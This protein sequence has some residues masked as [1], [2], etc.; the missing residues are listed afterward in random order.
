LLKS[1]LTGNG[2]FHVE[3][4]EESQANWGLSTSTSGCGMLLY[5]DSKAEL[6]KCEMT[7]KRKTLVHEGMKSETAASN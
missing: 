2:V 5:P 6:E 4:W 3:L 1:D 7:G